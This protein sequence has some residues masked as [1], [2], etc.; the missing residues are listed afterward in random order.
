MDTTCSRK[1][2]L[3]MSAN[4]GCGMGAEFMIYVKSFDI[5]LVFEKNLV[6]QT[7]G[8]SVVVIQKCEI[9]KDR[10]ALCFLCFC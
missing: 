9:R 10:L 4:N 6:S 1:K 3:E 7:V 5:V 2:Q 8:S